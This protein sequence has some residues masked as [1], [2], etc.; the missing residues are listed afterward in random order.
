VHVSDK[1]RWWRRIGVVLGLVFVWATVVWVLSC[2]PY[3]QAVHGG[4][5][6]RTSYG[7]LR[8]F[9]V[10]APHEQAGI[11]SLFPLQVVGASSFR[12]VPTMVSLA[13]CVAVTA[14]IVAY[15]RRW[16][17]NLRP[18]GQCKNCGYITNAGDPRSSVCSECGKPP[19]LHWRIEM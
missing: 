14:V 8:W 4:L 15:A 19:N 18:Y 1:E 2:F 17:R 12:P 6:V 7:V 3:S 5:N 16:L 11:A 9:E 13:I 10:T